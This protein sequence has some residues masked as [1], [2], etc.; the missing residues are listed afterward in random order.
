MIVV[1]SDE[2]GIN[3]CYVDRKYTGCD[4]AAYS[5]SDIHCFKL[6]IVLCL[7]IGVPLEQQHAQSWFNGYACKPFNWEALLNL[8][9]SHLPPLPT[10][11]FM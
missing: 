6:V 5:R 10:R 8:P 2:V 1:D 3:C 9:S 7:V 4:D 11:S